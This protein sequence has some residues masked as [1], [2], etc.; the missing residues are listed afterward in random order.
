M[1]SRRVKGKVSIFPY[2]NG[3][4]AYVW[5]TT[6]AA[7]RTTSSLEL[8]PYGLIAFASPMSSRGS[9]A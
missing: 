6:S 5:I 1:T 2:R 9:I 4:A 8:V 3:F 7:R